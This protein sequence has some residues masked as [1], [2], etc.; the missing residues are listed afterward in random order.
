M[1]PTKPTILSRLVR[2]FTTAFRGRPSS[3]GANDIELQAVTTRDQSTNALLAY[4]DDTPDALGVG[5]VPAVL[6]VDNIEH[7]TRSSMI[8]TAE[9]SD[10]ELTLDRLL[11][12]SPDIIHDPIL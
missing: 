5:A 9:S 6:D 2:P 4:R 3:S 8:E 12:A 11:R 10:S 1:K 7:F